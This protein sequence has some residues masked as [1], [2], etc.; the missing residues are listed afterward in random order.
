[1]HIPLCIQIMHIPFSQNVQRQQGILTA[2]DCSQ[3]PSQV[4]DKFLECGSNVQYKWK[5]TLLDLVY[6]CAIK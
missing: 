5:G 4:F 1:M 2:K 6:I 3:K